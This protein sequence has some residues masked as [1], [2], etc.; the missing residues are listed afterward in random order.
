MKTVELAATA[1]PLPT[2]GA[3]PFR[4]TV[5]GVIAGCTLAEGY[6]YDYLSRT[7]RP[8]F[9]RQ[10]GGQHADD[11]G[12]DLFMIVLESIRARKLREPGSLN[13]YA[14]AIAQRLVAQTIQRLSVAR[15]RERPSDGLL[16]G[17]RE[18]PEMAC[19]RTETVGLMRAVLSELT[20]GER[21]I[22]RRFYLEE[23]P[24]EQI[25]SEMG[26]SP[27]QFRLAKWRAKERF[28]VLGR[29]K[30]KAPVMPRE[31]FSRDGTVAS[32]STAAAPSPA[33]C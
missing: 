7:F 25:R 18:N 6:L 28:G 2:P 17:D 27:N 21:A 10:L 9:I 32:P 31:A 8:F 15:R 12:A 4:D 24:A 16:S 23:Q 30:L 13:A 20:P 19:Q 5:A 1:P 11:L 26:L 22:L 33:S 3:D 29:R 14:F